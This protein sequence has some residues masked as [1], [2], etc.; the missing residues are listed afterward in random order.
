MMNFASD[1]GIN[2][3][4]RSRSL[5][6]FITNYLFYY[7]LTRQTTLAITAVTSK[8]CISHVFCFCFYESKRLMLNSIKLLE[9]NIIL[10]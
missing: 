4:Q 1:F 10:R 5:N 3:I 7:L 8:N 6:S 2:K 9:N